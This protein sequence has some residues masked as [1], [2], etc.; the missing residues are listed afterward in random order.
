MTRLSLVLALTLVG[1]PFGSIAPFGITNQPS[2]E[3]KLVLSYF[4]DVLDGGKGDLVEDMF[5]PDYVIHFASGDVKGAAG[6]HA[7]VERRVASAIM[8]IS[9][10]QAVGSWCRSSAQWQ[11]LSAR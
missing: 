1:F 6:L 3:E 4:H 10:R 5:Q 7:M 11:S 2:A 9:P 8:S